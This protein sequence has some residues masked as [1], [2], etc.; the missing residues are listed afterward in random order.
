VSIKTEKDRHLD[1]LVGVCP[2]SPSEEVVANFTLRKHDPMKELTKQERTPPP[3][4]LWVANL[5]DLQSSLVRRMYF[6][7]IMPF[8]NLT[9]E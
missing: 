3:A 6:G 4:R 8:Q 2:A 9:G 1:V 5:F 7:T